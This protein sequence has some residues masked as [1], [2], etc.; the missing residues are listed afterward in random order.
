MSKISNLS[1]SGVFFRAPNAPK[2]VFSQTPLGELI[3]G[4]YD[5]S[6][7]FQSVLKPPPIKIAGLSIFLQSY[8]QAWVE[9][10]LFIY[11]VYLQQIVEQKN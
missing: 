9:L 4:A 7:T 10:L 6:P 11:R 2:P 5:A 3:G 8:T 1:S